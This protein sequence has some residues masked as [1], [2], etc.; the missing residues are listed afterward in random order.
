MKGPCEKETRGLVG[1][2]KR[3][4]EGEASLLKLVNGGGG[5]N[6]EARRVEEHSTEKH[7]KLKRSYTWKKN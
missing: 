6:R 3:G 7:C 4:E 1:K 5:N 2:C